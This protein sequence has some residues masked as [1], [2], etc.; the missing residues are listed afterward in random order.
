MAFDT[1]SAQI[2]YNVHGG[3]L[4]ISSTGEITPGIAKSWHVEGG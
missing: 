1:Q 4:L 3:L 2:L